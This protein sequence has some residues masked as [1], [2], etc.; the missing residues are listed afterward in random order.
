M[1]EA[2]LAL[3]FVQPLG[4]CWQLA[5]NNGLICHQVRAPEWAKLKSWDKETKHQ[6]T[7][8]HPSSSN[9]LGL[10]QVGCPAGWAADVEMRAQETMFSLSLM[11]PESAK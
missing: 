5:P 4:S 2:S 7:F 8:G 10:L 11:F 3:S 9:V 6:T 1:E